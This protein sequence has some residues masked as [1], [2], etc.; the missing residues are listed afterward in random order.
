MSQDVLLF[1]EGVQRILPGLPRVLWE[2]A[3]GIRI[4]L[5]KRFKNGRAFFGDHLRCFPLER[6]GRRA[7]DAPRGRCDAL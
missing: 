4:R 3:F 6:S 5:P 1:L 2:G 7:P